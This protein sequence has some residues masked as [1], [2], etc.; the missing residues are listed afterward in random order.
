MV[1]NNGG[2]NPDSNAFSA[3][4]LTQKMSMTLSMIFLEVFI[5]NSCV[6]SLPNCQNQSRISGPGLPLG[7]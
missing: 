6:K 5:P 1:L 2:E 7:Q 4:L 3:I